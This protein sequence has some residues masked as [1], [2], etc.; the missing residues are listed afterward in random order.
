MSRKRSQ[1]DPSFE[2]IQPTLGKDRRA[3]SAGVVLE[4]PSSTPES[5]FYARIGPVGFDLLIKTGRIPDS[6]TPLVHEVLQSGADLKVDTTKIEGL[7]QLLELAEAVCSLAFLEPRVVNN[8]TADDEI[9]MND[10][11]FEDKMFILGFFQEPAQ[12]L[13]N[14]REEQK[15]SVEPLYDVED[16]ER[17]A[18]HDPE[19]ESVG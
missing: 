17:E 9:G 6:L 19:A 12:T 8:P 3:F 4:L 5:R 2:D 1:S 18:Q 7:Q 14:F 11:S 16:I 13:R 10:L 15:R